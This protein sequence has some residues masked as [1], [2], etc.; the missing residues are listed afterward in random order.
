MTSRDPKGDVRKYAIQATAWLLVRN[1]TVLQASETLIVIAAA[2]Q[3]Y[4]NS[5]PTT[6][7]RPNRHLANHMYSYRLIDSMYVAAKRA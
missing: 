7:E 6:I 5:P 2:M 4:W 1:V 3:A